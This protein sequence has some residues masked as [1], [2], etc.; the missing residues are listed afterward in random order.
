MARAAQIGK[1]GSGEQKLDREWVDLRELT[2]YAAGF[3][4]H[5]VC[6]SL[7]R[8]AGLGAPMSEGLLVVTGFQ[9]ATVMH[10]NR[11][12]LLAFLKQIHNLIGEF[13]R[14]LKN[15]SPV[16]AGEQ[17]GDG[18]IAIAGPQ[19][20]EDINKGAE[21]STGAKERASIQVD[22]KCFP[23]RAINN[24]DLWSESNEGLSA[25]SALRGV[26]LQ[27]STPVAGA[28]SARTVSERGPG[29]EK[30]SG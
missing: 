10:V 21:D 7:N 11:V 9:V 12:K 2:Q 25:V 23:V 5:R 27:R 15:P 30:S 14:L 18:N 3:G 16:L 1:R 26:S 8:N 22:V 19:L 28:K 24:W 4:A 20:I 13:L 6:Q 17:D 29:S